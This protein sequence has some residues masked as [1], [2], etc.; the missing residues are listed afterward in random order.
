MAEASPHIPVLYR[1]VLDAFSDVNEGSII[2]CTMGYAGHSSMLL[3]ANKR[4]RLIGIDQDSTAIAFSTKRLAPFGERAQIKKGRFS[5][6]IGEI[7]EAYGK[8]E[9]KG[10]LADI[11]VSSLQLDQS[12]RGFSFESDVLDMRMDKEAPLSAAEVVNTY[13][14]SELE[15]ILRDYG[16]IRNARKIA[17]VIVK[18]RPFSSAKALSDAVRPFMPRGKKIHPATLVMQAIRIEVNDELGELNRLL[19]AIEAACL[20]D[21]VIAI[22]SF[23]SLEDRI[24]KQRFAKWAKSCICPPE[25]MRCTCGN[26]HDLGKIVT[27]KP[28]TARQDELKANARSR[29]AKLRIFKMACHER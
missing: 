24:V 9:I 17:S 3:E 21:A 28:V 22:I 5:S 2:D 15:R 16:E 19:D 13:D 26:D 7:I 10:V 18:N 1:E 23:H 27:K 20:P 11:G 14:E 29:S 25:A 12:E 6:V 4:I 8:E